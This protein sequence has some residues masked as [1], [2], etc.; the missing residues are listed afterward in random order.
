MYRL[1][2]T[3]TGELV[4]DYEMYLEAVNAALTEMWERNLNEGLIQI[5]ETG[6]SCG[7]YGDTFTIT[8]I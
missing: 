8:R 4:G 3:S 2:L 7:R 5:T 1:T 6:V